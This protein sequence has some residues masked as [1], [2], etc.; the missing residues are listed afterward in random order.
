MNTSSTRNPVREGAP[1]TISLVPELL[2]LRTL[3]VPTDFSESSQKAIHYAQ[4]LAQQFGGTI[5]LLHVIEPAYPY[6]VDGLVHVPGDLSDYN[7]ELLPQAER[8]LGS[9]ADVTARNGT[10]PVKSKI[11]TGSAHNEIV[12]AAKEEDAD[13]IVIATHGRTGLMHV[14]LGSTAEKVIRHSPCPVL[15]V[16]EKERDFA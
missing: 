14:L 12:K 9:L 13:L 1:K 8:S 7:L 6:P 3:L 10:V 2:H 4:R 15:V 5:L 11:R 16:R